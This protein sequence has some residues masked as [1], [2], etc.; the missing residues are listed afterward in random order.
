MS[1][2]VELRALHPQVCKTLQR[3]SFLETVRR[4]A[5]LG[6][7]PQFHANTVRLEML[8]HL[9]AVESNGTATPTRKDLMKLLREF[10]KESPLTHQ[11]DPV[12][13]VFIGCVNTIHGTFRVFSGIF[14]D[15]YFIV[16][17]L[18][19]FLA[20]KESFP[21]FRE[22]I[23]ATLGKNILRCTRTLDA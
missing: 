7:M 12:E 4:L 15:G 6:V 18:F 1:P 8:T 5:A 17:R 23:E 22:T 21:T 19:Q 16:E 11:E 3:Y 2:L 13:D 20:S 10:A 9:A 14:A